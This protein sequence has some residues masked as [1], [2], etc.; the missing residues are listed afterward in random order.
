MLGIPKT[1]TRFGDS[2]GRPTRLSQSFTHD[3]D[4]LQR[5]GTKQNPQREKAQGAKSGGN[6]AEASVSFPPTESHRTLLYPA[7][8]CNV[9]EKAV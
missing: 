6:K 1:T 5:K 4:S 3:Y 2:L 8:S 9:Y 7:M